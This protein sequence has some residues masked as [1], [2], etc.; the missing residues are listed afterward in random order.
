[1]TYMNLGVVFNARKENEHRVPIHPD[2][3]ELIPEALRPHLFFENGYGEPFGIPDAELGRRFGGVKTRDGIV[4]QSEIV[5]LPKP[6]AE[7]LRE[8]HDGA[9]VWGWPHCVQQQ[10]ITQVSI[11]RK[12][13]LLAFEAMFTWKGDNRDMHLFYRN[14][15]MAGYCGVIHALGLAGMDGNYGPAQKG[16]VLSLGSVSRGAVYALRGRGVED[17]TV[18][19][20]RPAWAVHDQ[21]V[22]CKYGQM[23]REGDGVAVIEPDGRRRPMIESLA[24]ANFI[25]NGILQDTDRPLMFMKKGEEARLQRAALIVDV[26]CDLEMGFPFARPTSFEKPIFD[27][28]HVT[29]YAVDHTPTYSWRAASWEISR[30]VV[31]FLEAVMSGPDGWAKDETLRRSIEIREGVI[32]NEKVLSFQSRGADYPHLVKE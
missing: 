27:V 22:G 28:G 21:V 11:D 12:L 3:F 15:E 2:H 31:S 1:M 17:I 4:G 13:T 23:V 25:V 24:E 16:V 18:Y 32:Q 8:M 7:D 6:L 26:S 10:E 19:T 29:Y 20:Q 9:V 14:N 5:L 30:V